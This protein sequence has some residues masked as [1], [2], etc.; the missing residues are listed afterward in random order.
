MDR[1]TDGFKSLQTGSL[2][3]EKAQEIQA[4]LRAA[5]DARIREGEEGGS[6][7]SSS[8]SKEELDKLKARQAMDRSAL[9]R[10]WMAGETEGW[11]ERRLREEQQALDE[12]K[13]YGD[14]IKKHIW[15][16]WNWEKSGKDGLES[17]EEKK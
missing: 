13:G 17:K 2:P 10:V 3:T 1:I 6:E 12:G 7:E 9:E 14:L 4:K 8:L 16:V 15:E 5:R 11:K